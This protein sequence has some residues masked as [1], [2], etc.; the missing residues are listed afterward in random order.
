V[1]SYIFEFSIDEKI[2]E[3]FV[4]GGIPGISASIFCILANIVTILGFNIPQFIQ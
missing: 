4:R 2:T 3:I 1:F